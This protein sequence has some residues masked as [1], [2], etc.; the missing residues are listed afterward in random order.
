M[1]LHSIKTKNIKKIVI[2]LF[3]WAYAIFCIQD[4]G[5]QILED[6]ELVVDCLSLS[7]QFINPKL[8]IGPSPYGHT[9]YSGIIG[10]NRFW[11]RCFTD[12]IIDYLNKNFFKI[13][14]FFFNSK[15]DTNI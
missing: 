14:R 2:L 4:H 5:A 9:K 3:S 6:S 11:A 7:K 13:K 10:L 8:I 1:D 12:S 15:M